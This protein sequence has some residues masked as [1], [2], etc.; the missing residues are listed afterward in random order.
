MTDQTA[1]E[2]TEPDTCC[3]TT[4]APPAY[5]ELLARLTADHDQATRNAAL[6]RTPE[7]RAA[8]SGMAAEAR[9]AVCW[10]LTVFEGHAAREAWLAGLPADAGHHSTPARYPDDTAAPREQAEARVRDL[11]AELAALR[12]VSRGYCP[13]CGRGD[14]APTVEHWE[15][16]R[17]RA[18]K[19]EAALERVRRLAQYARDRTAAG[20]SDW[21]IRQHELALA[22]L[23]ALA[24]QPE[25]GRNGGEET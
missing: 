5:R 3:R 10:A 7:T 17:Q 13:S 22:V 19:A 6:A 14:A 4:A 21:V 20:E 24:G 1:T 15:R 12:V 8:L 23:D 18:D 16:E 2:A 9:T 25:S 11:E